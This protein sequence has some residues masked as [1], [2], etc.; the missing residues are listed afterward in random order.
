MDASIARAASVGMRP[1]VPVGHLL[2][3][4]VGILSSKPEATLF[5]A[6]I[7]IAT[8]SSAHPVSIRPGARLAHRRESA[9]RALTCQSVSLH[10]S[11]E[12]RS[13]VESIL[14][15]DARDWIVED[16]QLDRRPWTLQEGE[17]PA[18]TL[19]VAHDLE[20]SIGACLTVD[21]RARYVGADPGGQPLRCEVREVPTRG[22][23]EHAGG[24]PTLGSRL[25]ERR[26][27]QATT[28]ARVAHASRRRSREMNDAISL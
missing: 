23:N 2:Q 9:S 24:R 18:Q 13:V 14:I 1:I 27:A 26:D 4:E 25:E 10:V 16:V 22:R 7:G 19:S 12:Q 28:R 3:C 11:L 6:A 15:E 17:F 21:I 20:L 8:R 5:A